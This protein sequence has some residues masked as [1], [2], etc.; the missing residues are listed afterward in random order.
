MKKIT[1]ILSFL[2]ATLAIAQDKGTIQ[3]V[4]LDKEIANEPLPFANIFIKDSQIGTTSDIEGIYLFTADPG[5]YTLIFSF[6]GYQKVE[7]PNIVVKSGEVT[8]LENVILGATEGVSLKE[9]IVKATTQKES[10]AALLTEQKKAVQIKTSIGA[11]E[12]GKLGVSDAATATTKISGITQSEGSGDVFIRGLGDRYLTTTMNGL[13][14]P[15]D[16]VEKKN[17][18]LNLFSTSIIQNIGVSKAYNVENYADQA[19]GNVDIV[20]KEAKGTSFVIG[21][22][23]GASLNVL[24]VSDFKRTQNLSDLSLGFYQ[25]AYSTQQAITQQSWNTEMQNST[26]LNLGGSLTLNSRID[27]FGRPLGIFVTAS[28]ATTFE[29]SMGE[30]RKFRSNILNN[31][32]TDVETFNAKTNTTGLVNL[33]YPV[34]D[35]LKL[36]YSLLAINK[37]NDQVYESGRNLEGYVF[38][39]DPSEDQAFVRDQNTKVTQLLVNQLLGSYSV[40]ETNELNWALGYNFITANEPNRIRNEVNTLNTNVVEFSNVGNF[41][42][43][44]SNQQIEDEEINGFIKDTWTLSDKDS[45]SSKINF[46]V[47]YRNRKRNL[48]S[49]FVGVRARGVQVASIDDLSVAFTPQAF[50]AASLNFLYS[51]YLGELDILAPFAAFEFSINKLNVSVGARYEQVKLNLPYWDVPNF[52]GRVG[53]L[54]TNYDNLFPSL[55]LKYALNERVNLRLSAA[56]TITLPEFKEIAPFEYNDPTGRV[57]VGNPDLIASTDYNFDLKYEFF[58]SAGQLI[59]FAGFYK[60]IE[61]PINTALTR[62]SSGNFSYFNTGE[63]ATVFGLELETRFDLINREEGAKLNLVFNAA[64]MWHNQD[65]SENFQYKERTESGLQ[66]ASDFIMNTGLT[67]SNGKENEFLASLSGNYA[68]D[69][70]YSLGSPEDFTNSATLYNDEIIEKGFATIDLLLSKTLNKKFTIKLTGKN[71]LDPS[72][73]QTQK[74]KNLNT[75]VETNETVLS[76]KKGLFLSLGI[77]YTF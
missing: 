73:K 13:P 1:L 53:S 70:I 64:T 32:F 33:T 74:I 11:E 63:K 50:P 34:S 22:T 42:Q 37:S 65:L 52:Q 58:P 43:R 15:S 40:N 24:D 6:V 72:I 59:S 3:G 7:V 38:D 29:Y 14:I 75:Q 71:L 66:G 20:S 68:S 10:V 39:Q 36:K 76:Y 25:K 62:G 19:S 5:T 28:H 69:K 55:N 23:V 51:A 45:S 17:I 61:D 57:T 60:I 4:I 47:S 54:E 41:Q 48:Q 35:K 8:T 21:L 2:L 12:L 44:K 56:K 27:V 67:Y 26:P 16:N 30:F 31:E 9:V 49:Q 46:G 18:D 77:N